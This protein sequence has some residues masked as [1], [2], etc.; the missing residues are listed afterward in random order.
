MA[1]ANSTARALARASRA[2]LPNAAALRETTSNLPCLSR[3]CPPSLTPLFLAAANASRV[4]REIAR[5]SSSATRA[6]SSVTRLPT[7]SGHFRTHAL[8]QLRPYSMTSLEP[9]ETRAATLRPGFIRKSPLHSITL[10]ARA[11]MAS[12][13]VRPMAAAA[14]RFTASSNVTGS[15]TGRSAGGVPL[16]ILSTR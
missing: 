14:L 9:G 5:P 11:R 15:S 4:R 8:Q 7:E 2:A 12:G 3:R 13:I 10:S 1:G 16:K 6:M